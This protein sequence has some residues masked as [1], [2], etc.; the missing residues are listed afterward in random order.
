M[1]HPNAD[2][3]IGKSQTNPP[4]T[5]GKPTPTNNQ[6]ENAAPN[7]AT[8]SIPRTSSQPQP[9]NEGSNAGTKQIS[10]GQPRGR[11][12]IQAEYVPKKPSDTSGTGNTGKSTTPSS[13]INNS[14]KTSTTTGNKGTT[15]A[16]TKVSEPQHTTEQSPKQSKAAARRA[17]RELNAANANTSS[18]SS[19]SNSTAL[20]GTPTAVTSKAT[21]V[22][23]KAEPVKVPIDRIS[24]H[25]YGY[26]ILRLQISED[27]KIIT[28]LLTSIGMEGY[29]T[30]FLKNG[31]RTVDSL[32][33]LQKNVLG[34]MG[35]QTIDH[36]LE[37]LEAIQK[38]I[39][40]Q[41]ASNL[42]NWGVNEVL[43]WLDTLDPDLAE[44]K[45]GKSI[46]DH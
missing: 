31:F 23:P 40:R 34:E 28:A 22:Q 29:L 11:T 12:T 39:I 6:K 45:E 38:K 8:T 4:A 44:Y 15:V 19:S 33:K 10:N 27:E 5:N 17:R 9:R 18:P 42:L 41:P 43:N 46:M 21:T 13:T 30:T 25:E 36:Q 14:N 32:F 20:A 37:I 7:S 16:S 1:I 26:N 3:Q 35:I 2:G 24:F